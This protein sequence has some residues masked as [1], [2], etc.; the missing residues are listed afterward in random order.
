MIFKNKTIC[1]L[2]KPISPVQAFIFNLKSTFVLHYYT[3]NFNPTFV[4]ITYSSLIFPSLYKQ[5]FVT[6]CQLTHTLIVIEMQWHNLNLLQLNKKDT[7]NKLYHEFMLEQDV[8]LVADK[9]V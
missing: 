5:V 4:L 6:Y 8:M 3:F 7:R 2:F 1:T 9:N